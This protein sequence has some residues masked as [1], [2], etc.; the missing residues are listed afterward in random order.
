MRVLFNGLLIHGNL[1]GVQNYI[2]QLMNEA[3]NNDSFEG[4]F[5]PVLSKCILH[6]N[7][8]H[9]HSSH[10]ILPTTINNRFKRIILE[11]TLLKQLSN[12]LTID[13]V[14]CPGYIIPPLIDSSCVL[15][16]HD[17]IAIDYPQFCKNTN[18]L[19]F[20]IFMKQ[21]VKKAS[22]II[23]V[24][25]TVKN[26]IIKHYN[27]DSNKISVIPI[28]INPIFRK[29]ISRDKLEQVKIKYQLPNRYILF[30]GNIEP[31]KN[32]QNLINA[33]QLLKQEQKNDLFLVIVGQHG[34]KCKNIIKEIKYGN[35]TNIIWLDYVPTE[36]LPTIYSLSELFVFPS[37]Y[38]GFGIPPQEAR[39]CQIPAL[40]SRCG[41]LEELAPRGSIFINP[42]SK[43]D[44][45]EKIIFCL[46]NNIWRNSI[47]DAGLKSAQHYT[48]EV[49][50]EKT[51]EVYRKVYSEKL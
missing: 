35:S 11:N 44:I 23:A 2:L 43:E 32:V 40:T 51:Q 6:E 3:C 33:F 45:A 5:I 29:K 24:S 28:G 21:S 48:W 49:A 27:I 18:A 15:T 47:I 46:H 7:Y 20:N 41:A 16:I 42:N 8:Y 22:H 17:T 1:S 26:D 14:H 10:Y 34:W 19:Y 30:V 9:P 12:S 4:T 25:K 31:K 37:F 38:E 36:D 13:I 39:M 50:W